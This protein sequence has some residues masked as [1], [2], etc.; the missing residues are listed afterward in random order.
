MATEI[1]ITKKLDNNHVQVEITPK[2]VPTR[3][4][5]VPTQKADEFCKAYKNFDKE[6]SI[7]SAVR[8]AFPTVLLCGIANHFTKGK[9]KVTQ[10]GAGVGI[11]ILS[12]MGTMRWNIK[13]L[14]KK[15]DKLLQQFNA[16]E[17]EKETMPHK[18]T[19]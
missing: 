19:K 7:W 8:I 18:K 12:M 11:G 1:N 16:Q 15:E 10:W 17:F 14:I 4:F 5:K 2:K 6:Q 13:T 9:S 3:Y